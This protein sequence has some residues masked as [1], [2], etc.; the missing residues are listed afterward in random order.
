MDSTQY[1]S[2]IDTLMTANAELNAKMAQMQLH[3]EHEA[4]NFKAAMEQKFAVT[5]AAA[6]AHAEQLTAELDAAREQLRNLQSAHSAEPEPDI[7]MAEAS[8]TGKSVPKAANRRQEPPPPR[9]RDPRLRP[10]ASPPT[11]QFSPSPGPDVRTKAR[12]T[13]SSPNAKEARPPPRRSSRSSVGSKGSQ[14]SSQSPPTPS[15]ATPTKPKGLQSQQSPPASSPATPK[16]KLSKDT[17]SPAQSPQ[18]RRKSEYQVLAGE[19]APNAV[20]TKTAF[21]YHLCFLIGALESSKAPASASPDAV[22][23]FNTRFKEFTVGQLRRM[24]QSGPNLIALEEVD[25]GLRATA[26]H[27]RNKIISAFRKLEESALFH[28][29]AYLAKLGI[30]V[31]APDFNQTPYSLYN[32]AMRMSAIDTFRFLVAATHYD[33]LEPNTQLVRDPSVLPKMYDHFVHHYLF[34]Q[35]KLETRQPGGTVMAADRNKAVVNRSRVRA[36]LE[37]FCIGA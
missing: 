32:M 35:W 31:W 26:V 16:P 34:E 3:F 33:F 13:H 28:V 17:A 5:H 8:Q 7:D 9:T 12:D 23:E 10:T 6:L 11:S 21:Q 27:S 15:C 2:N 30:N 25:V 20:K 19:T 24:G 18:T 1:S 4:A 36:I 22:A 14:S 29:R 37:K